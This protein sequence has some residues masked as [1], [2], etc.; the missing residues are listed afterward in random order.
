MRTP[1][2]ARPPGPDRDPDAEEAWLAGLA[3]LAA[4][5]HAGLTGD[6]LSRLANVRVR[7]RRGAFAADGYAGPAAAPALRR[8][9]AP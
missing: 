6:E 7:A 9:P 5:L 8:R 4:L 2:A 3:A 1:A